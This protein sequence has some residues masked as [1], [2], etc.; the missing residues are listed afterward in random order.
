MKSKKTIL[1]VE[2]EFI[3]A[4]KEKSELE[5]KGYIVHHIGKG[6]K[7]VQAILD[8]NLAADLVLMDIDLGRGIDGTQAAQQI[9]E[10]RDIP[11]VFLSSHIEPEIVAKTEKITSYGYVVK[12][13]G[14]FVLDASMKMALKLFEARIRGREAEAE[15][16]EK[17][18]E[19]ERFF[20]T[21]LDMLCIADTDGY[22]RRLNQEWE[23]VLGYPP[24]ELTDRKFLDFVHPDDRQATLDKISELENNQMVINFTNRYRCSDGS[25]RWLEWRSIPHGKLIYA[26]ARD[27]SERIKTEDSL[28]KL[29]T[30]QNTLISAI[31]D[32]VMEVDNN[33]VYTWANRGGYEF[34]GDDVIG[35]EASYYF[36][37]AQETYEIV[38]PV[39]KG[40]EDTIYVESWQRRKD[41]EKRLLGWWCRTLKGPDS[42]VIGALSTAHD[43]TDYRQAE[44]A[45]RHE[46]ER[47]ENIISGTNIGTWEWNVQ[48]GELTVNK[49]WAELI[50]YTLAELAP[51]SIQTWKQHVHPD[52][53]NNSNEL[54]Q[55][56]FNG[57]LDYYRSESRIKHKNGHWVWILDCGK[58]FSR[59]AD[60]KPLMMMGSHHD[61]TKLKEAESEIQK[62]L[63]E[64]EI[65]LKEVH[66]RVKNNI[67]NIEGF[68]SLQAT[69][70]LM[71]EVRTAL[72][73]AL[74]RVQGMRVLFEKLLLSGDYQTIPLKSY[75]ESLIE[76]IISVFPESRKITINKN[77]TDITLPTKTATS[78]G[79]IINELL[80]NVFKY[81]FSDF[82]GACVTINF[83]K[84]DGNAI[85]S[86]H[87]N[88]IG[89]DERTELNKSHGF[90]LLIVKMMA[91]QLGGTF[92]IRTDNGTTSVLGF[93]T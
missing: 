92:S 86:I 12:S 76:S 28:R 36:E 27:I 82:T 88:G 47:L 53:L 67:A 49:R 90:G 14:T 78:I 25:Y 54:L 11:I 32:I 43:I 74:L 23:K 85:L 77:I 93:E 72:Q 84:T 70:Q 51:V 66:H 39:F 33:K 58:V 15:I 91:E 61:I 1:L 31:P 64:K 17:T 81:A 10:H 20:A 55:K 57:Q 4:M 16:S 42:E 52:D 68:L 63:S 19:L 18:G 80:T 71:P 26:C 35:K 22:F 7:A 45:L 60:G 62:Q 44:E 38:Q 73:D 30:R 48:T 9:L 5:E 50:G 2:D 69:S 56:H 79:I 40:Y 24:D 41:G 29:V 21:S 46:R 6:E 65:L 83:S 34:F 59:T 75:V 87:D 13:A 3:I 37:D 8:D 89:M